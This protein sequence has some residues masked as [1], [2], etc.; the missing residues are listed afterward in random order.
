[1]LGIAFVERENLT[2]F[3][4][5]AC[6]LCP[7][8]PPTSKVPCAKINSGNPVYQALSINWMIRAKSDADM[9]STHHAE[10]ESHIQ[11][12]EGAR[13]SAPVHALCAKI[14]DGRY[15]STWP[16]Q[17]GATHQVGHEVGHF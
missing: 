2:E 8:S 13:T 10:R 11:R 3:Y 9:L 5:K 17:V 14:A 15:F 6:Q 16:L 1:M 7:A 12:R 4:T